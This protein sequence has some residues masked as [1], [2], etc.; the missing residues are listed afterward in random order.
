MYRR[1]VPCSW[2]FGHFLP[3]CCIL[4]GR[5]VEYLSRLLRAVAGFLVPLVGYQKPAPGRGGCVWASAGPVARLASTG[6][7][8]VAIDRQGQPIDCFDDRGAALGGDRQV[9]GSDKR[10][11]PRLDL[12][13]SHAGTPQ[14]VGLAS[15]HVPND[16]FSTTLFNF[17][18]FAVKQC[19]HAGPLAAAKQARCYYNRRNDSCALHS[20]S[21]LGMTLAVNASH[22]AR[23]LK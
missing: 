21:S 1:L 5:D 10:F 16:R 11:R 6:L 2:L 20:A 8:S 9:V 12:R 18:A 15:S 17:D 13:F 4:S 3:L 14:N 22:A 19:P 7:Y 23:L